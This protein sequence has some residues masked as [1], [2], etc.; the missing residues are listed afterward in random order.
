M[1]CVL[2]I[3]DVMRVRS[4]KTAIAVIR[5]IFQNNGSHMFTWLTADDSMFSADAGTPEI[6]YFYPHEPWESLEQRVKWSDY[7]RLASEGRL[8][9]LLDAYAVSGGGADY[10]IKLSPELIG[11]AYGWM[12]QAERA[13]ARGV[14]THGLRGS[15][16]SRMV[17][18]PPW[19][20]AIEESVAFPIPD[21]AALFGQFALE[22]A[23]GQ[24]DDV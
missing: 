23:L 3:R 11:L 1:N 17:S 2:T 5:Y 8:D 21:A 4:T 7:A 19:L 14:E 12:A 20:D 6:G 10:W 16:P 15:I 9:R 18:A 22:Y 24:F 13:S